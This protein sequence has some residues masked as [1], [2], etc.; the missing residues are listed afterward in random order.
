MKWKYEI[1]MFIVLV[2]NI[3]IGGCSSSKEI[4]KTKSSFERIKLDSFNSFDSNQYQ[5]ESAVILEAFKDVS[6][7]INTS[8]PKHLSPPI[9]RD[10]RELGL[11]PYYKPYMFSV[12]T[13]SHYRIKIL[14]SEGIKKEDVILNFKSGSSHFPENIPI[15]AIEGISYTSWNGKIISNKIDKKDIKIKFLNDSISQ[16]IFKIPTVKVGSI[17]EVKYIKFRYASDGIEDENFQQD[18]PVIKQYYR[19]AIP[20]SFNYH[21]VKLG[22]HP[23]SSLKKVVEQEMSFVRPLTKSEGFVNVPMT[24]RWKFKSNQ[25]EFSTANLPTIK[26]GLSSETTGL[27]FI[28]HEFDPTLAQ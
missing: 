16:L 5:S 15:T 10:S 27:K 12:K 9:E 3:V 24:S 19:V 8:Y 2:I 23:I 20:L 14:S 25:Y 21:I 28:L 7:G 13:L 6:F 4:N 17:I 26:E 22:K 18:I 1:I 11:I